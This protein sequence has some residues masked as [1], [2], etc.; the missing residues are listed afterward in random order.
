MQVS[1]HFLHPSQ[2]TRV[3]DLT[4]FLWSASCLFPADVVSRDRIA[5]KIIE[6]VEA[7]WDGGSF[8]V[9]KDCHLL[10]DF[11]LSLAC[12][13]IYPQSLIEKIVNRILVDAVLKQQ[14]TVRQSRL[15]L[16]ITAAQ[17]EASHLTLEK[18]LLPAVA[19]G[20]PLYFK[21]EKELIKRPYLARLA[22]VID[23]HREEL[24]WENIQCCTTVPHL[25]LAGLTF[26]FK[27]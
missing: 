3:K 13:Q 23:R 6:Q 25:N 18:T 24:G 20:L 21:A 4:R 5:A 17:I 10:S 9:E 19:S 8:Q 1:H 22:G 27:G 11:F 15:A 7:G 26:N 12:W 16:F 2:G 14:Q